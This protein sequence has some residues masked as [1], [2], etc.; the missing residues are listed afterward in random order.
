MLFSIQLR[1]DSVLLFKVN[2][3]VA[4]LHSHT[5]VRFVFS[6]NCHHPFRYILILAINANSQ[7]L[8]LQ[9]YTL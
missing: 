6:Y 5:N 1:I 7:L 9:T 8:D 2:S 3:F 4:I